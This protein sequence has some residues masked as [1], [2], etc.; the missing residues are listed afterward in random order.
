MPIVSPV[1]F[2]S[3][4]AILAAVQRGRS[5]SKALAIERKRGDYRTFIKT[6]E[7]YLD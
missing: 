5:T 3:A 1:L 7:H 6:V 2:L 4:M